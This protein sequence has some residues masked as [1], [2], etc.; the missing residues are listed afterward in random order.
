MA[1]GVRG[2]S[3]FRD[4]HGKVDER[5]SHV[6]YDHQPSSVTLVASSLLS[7]ALLLHTAAYWNVGKS[8]YFN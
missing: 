1:R 2:R 5:L 3:A 4:A 7:Q 6:D 8:G